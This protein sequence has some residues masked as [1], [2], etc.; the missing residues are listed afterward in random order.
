M[1]P[2]LPPQRCSGTPIETYGHVDLVKENARFNLQSLAGY[3]QV[4]RAAP[5]RLMLKEYKKFF[6]AGPERQAA[7]ALA[8]KVVHITE[9]VARFYRSIHPW[10][11]GRPGNRVT[12]HSSCHLRA[13]GV[14]KEP[15]QLLRQ[16]PGADLCRDDRCGPMR[17]RGRYISRKGLRYRAEGIRPQASEYRAERCRHGCHQL[18][19]CLHDPISTM[20]CGTRG[21]QTWAQLLNDARMTRAHNSK[22]ARNRRRQDQEPANDLS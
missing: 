4:G 22:Q 2:E 19:P 17:R 9:F 15:R 18:V 5:A 6:E 1:N 8:K 3:D 16:V 13:A 12:Y 10:G 14:T 20:A 11:G 21:S 7:D